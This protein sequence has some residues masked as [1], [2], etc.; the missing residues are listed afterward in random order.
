MPGPTVRIGLPPPVSGLAHCRVSLA[1]NLTYGATLDALADPTGHG[2]R[3]VC[4]LASGPCCL[5]WTGDEHV[6][7]HDVRRDASAVGSADP[8]SWAAVA[9]ARRRASGLRGLL[10]RPASGAHGL[11]TAMGPLA[12]PL[13]AKRSSRRGRRAPRGLAP[14]GRRAGRGGLRRR[15][16]PDGHGSCLSRCSRRRARRK[17]RWLRPRALPLPGGRDPLAAALRRAVHHHR[18][19]A[20]DRPSRDRVVRPKSAASGRAGPAQAVG[21]PAYCVDGVE[22]VVADVVGREAQPTADSRQPTA[23]SR[24]PTADSRQPTA[25]GR[26][27]AVHRRRRH[28]VGA[29]GCSGQVAFAPRASS[30]TGSS[31]GSQGG[32][33][34][35]SSSQPR[36]MATCSATRRKAVVAV[37][38]SSSRHAR[39]Q[40]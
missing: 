10:A 7:H 21:H 35:E 31:E 33:C 20:A 30:R 37:V 5:T 6:G 36:S 9:G 29:L 2:G 19:V 12:G 3:S 25:G 13:A 26:V 14:S 8:R 16:R 4:G 22:G 34:T 38:V 40:G 24:Q 28:A 15:A 18:P 17:G 39:D 32:A 1:S 27:Q 23:D 11:G